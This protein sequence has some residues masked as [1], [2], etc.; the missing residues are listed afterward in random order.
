M[1]YNRLGRTELDVS[2]V[3]LGSAPF[4]NMFGE[5]SD[6][7]VHTTVRRA[8]DAGVNFFESSPFYGGGLAEERLGRALRGRRDEVFIG[9]K[10][11]RYGF[12]EFNFSPRRIR[13]SLERSLRLLGTDHVDV[14]QLHDIEFVELEGVF[15]DTYA[16]MVKLQDEGKCRYIG[17]TANPLKTL[18]RAVRETDIDVILSYAH[19]TLLNT[20]LRDE[21]EPACREKGVG[22]INAATVAFG[23]LTR[24]GLRIDIPATP[25]IKQAAARA[26]KVCE[27]HGA[28][29][30]FLANQFSI[31]RSGAATT[32][33]GTTKV[34]HLDAAIA[35]AEA[36]IDE[37]LLAAVLTETTGVHKT[38]W[39]SGL[40]E[41]N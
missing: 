25:V 35:A 14:F 10:A 34:R 2:Q 4:G 1:K 7:E 39:P 11:G 16:E 37:D 31:Q 24:P 21:L 20:Q 15:T 32:V 30:A 17:M 22:L 33:I 8:L 29:V 18:L 23:L 38:S 26:V 5:V 3:S 40:P 36:P 19:H 27:D 6:T 41:N 12:T 28:D 13:E 9:T